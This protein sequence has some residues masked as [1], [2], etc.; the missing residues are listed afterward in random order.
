MAPAGLFRAIPPYVYLH[1]SV[2]MSMNQNTKEFLQELVDLCIEHGVRVD[3]N[4]P[5]FV[6]GVSSKDR[7]QGMSLN[8]K[9]VDR[10]IAKTSDE[11]THPQPTLVFRKKGLDGPSEWLGSPTGK[12]WSS[13][14]A[15]AQVF[16]LT[17]REYMNLISKIEDTD[18]KYQYLFG[19]ESADAGRRPTAA[20][21]PK[22][23]PA[24]KPAKKR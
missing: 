18:R 6:V 11:I 2:S 19:H 13:D 4:K 10:A 16:T 23:S 15:K 22:K 21:V 8:L 24:K 1:F 9:V 7:T 3:R 14:R 5:A 12:S 17:L 20:S